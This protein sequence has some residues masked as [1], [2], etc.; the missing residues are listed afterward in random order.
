MTGRVNATSKVC[1]ICSTD[2]L[3]CSFPYLLYLFTP[4]HSNFHSSSPSPLFFL[5]THCSL[6]TPFPSPSSSCPTSR[7]SFSAQYKIE[8]RI[9]NH[10]TLTRMA[11]IQAVAEC[12]P[13]GF[14]VNLNDP[15]VFVLV[16][17]FKVRRMTG[18]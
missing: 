13:E 10:S 4:L 11:I 14:S 15:E 16:E 9:R 7:D 8:L 12:V 5:L 6:L 2:S 1:I 17:V 18:F 3:H